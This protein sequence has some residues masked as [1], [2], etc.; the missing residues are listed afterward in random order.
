M[1]EFLK[2]F[3]KKK[4]QTRESCTMIE[5]S[6]SN[7]ARG[8]LSKSSIE[9]P[10]FRKWNSVFITQARARIHVLAINLRIPWMLSTPSR[11]AFALAISLRIVHIIRINGSLWKNS[12][13]REEREIF[14]AWCVVVMDSLF[15]DRMKG[16]GR[17]E[18][19]WGVRS[20]EPCREQST[21][22][23]HVHVQPFTCT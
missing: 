22:A 8:I 23:T 5:T 14:V 13:R 6:C 12:I 19:V 15:E 3:L 9:F 16:G 10:K 1:S 18:G 11:D 21:P 20:R 17:G 7:R 4:Q 2:I